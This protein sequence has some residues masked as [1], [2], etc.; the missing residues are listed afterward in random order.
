MQCLL[1]NYDN[2]SHL[3]MSQYIGRANCQE[4]K[5]AA[6]PAYVLNQY[7]WLP[8][9]DLIFV[10]LDSPDERVSDE[11]ASHLR[12]HR[13]VVITSPFPKCLFPDL[14]MQPFAFLTAPFSFKKFTDCLNAYQLRQSSNEAQSAESFGLV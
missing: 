5:M 7:E 9:C 8:E 12:Q 11:L 6:N 1:I 13:G 4:I 3:L 14:F 10:H 2:G